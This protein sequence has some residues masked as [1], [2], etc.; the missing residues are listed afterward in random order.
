MADLISGNKEYAAELRARYKNGGAEGFSDTELLCL[1]LSFTN[2][3]GRLREVTAELVGTFGS[4]YSV[5]AASYSDLMSVRY[6][7]RSAAVLV[8]LVGRFIS[9]SEREYRE[10]SVTEYEAKFLEALKYCTEEEFWAAALGSDGA[11][12]ALERLSSGNDVSVDIS[13]S[14][15]V[16]FA[17]KNKTRRVIVAHSHPNA[18]DSVRSDTDEYS[19]NT[20]ATAL[21]GAGIVLDGHVIIANGEAKL[22]PLEHIH[23]TE[24]TY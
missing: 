16:R 2:V 8:L 18:N 5:Y 7:T 1:L 15:I 10:R 23:G 11:V 3:K 13:V 24:D 20:L 14:E 9:L 6:M 22:Y 21:H 19:M 4:V 17:V 12:Y